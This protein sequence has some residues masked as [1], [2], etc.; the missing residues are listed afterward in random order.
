MAIPSIGSL[1]AIGSGGRFGIVIG[2]R[3]IG[4][5]ENGE[6][7]IELRLKTIDGRGG[8]PG[9]AHL[10]TDPQTAIRDAQESRA[11]PLARPSGRL[12]LPP[13]SARPRGVGRLPDD[14]TADE[15]TVIARLQQRDAQVRQEENAHAAN[16]GDLAG[17]ISLV[18]QI[19]PDGRQ[20]AIGGSVQVSG[21]AVTG[22]P[23]EV[24]RLAG[25]IATAALAA[26]NPSAQD[27]AAAREGYRN[28]GQAADRLFRGSR[29]DISA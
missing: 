27:L 17:P 3:S 16:A 20:Y 12:A 23:D 2:A 24:A 6:Q 26:H 15:K 10:P 19:G 25:R 1:S 28:I 4:V 29:V 18:Y 8:R 7:L 22:D 9:T 13:P 14:L 21:Q 5:E 11:N